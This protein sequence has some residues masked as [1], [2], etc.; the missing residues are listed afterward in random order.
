MHMITDDDRLERP[1]AETDRAR[2]GIVSI[3]AKS[4]VYR[5]FERAFVAGTGLPLRLH[6][7]EMLMLTRPSKKQENPFCTLMAGVPQWAAATYQLQ[8]KLECEARFAPKTLRGFGGLCETSVPVRIGESP[9][10]YLH[11]GQ[12]LLHQPDTLEFDAIARTLTGW[13]AGVDVEEA[14][15]LWFGTRVIAPKQYDALIQL[16]DIFARHLAGC[17]NGLVLHHEKQMRPEITK[18]CA[19]IAEHCSDEIS[20]P[21][22]A[23]VAGM[24]ANYFSQVFAETSGIR[25]V[26]YVARTRVENAEHF[27]EDPGL[28]ISEIAFQVGFQSLSQFNRAF[29]KVAGCTPKGYRAGLAS[30]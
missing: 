26:E 9:V 16:I 19:Y 25:F 28:R 3:L 4:S 22:V 30:R 21:E 11:T 8:R 10:G 27:L 12:V 23:R 7:P 13:G 5:D 18:A 24:S 2:G 6:A 1:A 29:W 17:A 20:L 15:E 14:R